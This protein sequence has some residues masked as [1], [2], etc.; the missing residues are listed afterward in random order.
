MKFATGCSGIGVPDLA[1]DTIGWTPVFACEREPFP[2]AVLA[3]RFGYGA[4]DGPALLDDFLTIDPDAWPDI[5]AFIAGTPCQ[6]FSIAGARRG[7]EDE[8]GNLTLKFVELCHG[9]QEKT[10]ENGRSFRWAVWEN[11]PGVLSDKTNAFGTFISALVGGSEALRPPG[12]GRDDWHPDKEPSWPSAGMVSGPRARLAWRVLDSQY[13]GV[14]QRRRRVFVVVSFGAGDPAAVLFEPGCLQRHTEAGRRTRKDVAGAL[15][16]SSGKRCGADEGDRGTIIPAVAGC[17]QERDHKGAD[18]DTKP[19]HLIP[20]T[21]A[22]QERAAAKKEDTGPDGKGFRDDGKA[23]TLEARTIP[24]AVAFTANDYAQ[25]SLVEK[26]P[27]LRAGG[28]D[29]SHQNGGIAPAVVFDTTQV[30]SKTNRSNPKPGDPCHTI[31]AN[32]EPPSIAY[33]S[34][35]RKLTPRECERLQGLPDDFTL[36]RTWNKKR[37]G[38]QKDL[39]ETA[40]WIMSGNGQEF[41]IEEARQLAAHPDGPRYKALGNAWTYNVG[42]WV[43][44]RLD[45]ED[46][47]TRHVDFNQSLTN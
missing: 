11:V 23:F 10:H 14:A 34:A 5:E 4:D 7:L 2:R 15:S 19:G 42:L 36:L 47:R 46:R 43:L 44:R 12:G 22:I 9:F 20:V 29:K 35:V 27:T 33:T 28:H 16:A 21:F 30:T 31:P 45:A 24:Q 26:S 17:L 37:P 1:A 40:R 8:R 32:G 3:E 18:S 25:D 39:E 6:S 38:W 13:F 41:T